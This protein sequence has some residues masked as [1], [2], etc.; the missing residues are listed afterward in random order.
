MNVIEEKMVI[1]CTMEELSDAL[2]L[3]YQKDTDWELNVITPK[4][5]L[6]WQLDDDDDYYEEEDDEDVPLVETPKVDFSEDDRKWFEDNV[7]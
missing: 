5:I 7:L 1:E 2:D 3:L 4:G 6:V